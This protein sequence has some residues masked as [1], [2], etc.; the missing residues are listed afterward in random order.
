MERIVCV[1]GADR[2]LG[3]S[4]VKKFLE[5]HYT[6]FAGKYLKECNDLNDLQEAYQGKLF[7]VRLDISND[8]SVKQAADFIGGYTDRIDILVNNGAILGDINTGIFDKMD[9]RE[10]LEV[11]NTNTLGALRVTN[12]LIGLLIKSTTRLI[13][14]ISSEAGSI[15]DCERKSWFGYCMAKA[16][17]NMQS[18]LIHNGI[19]EAGGQ[20]LVLHPG[21]LQTYMHGYKNMEAQYTADEAAA[22]LFT[23]I[24]NHKAY[25]GEEPVF[26]DLHG[27]IHPW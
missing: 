19:K 5:T 7:L 16:A 20:V 10:I 3:L 24:S 17:L 4:L 9:F 23:I 26:I 14:N 18:S 2:G 8:F 12:S 25:K 13:V 15:A 11:F 22:K 21:W 1:T 6:V 27:E